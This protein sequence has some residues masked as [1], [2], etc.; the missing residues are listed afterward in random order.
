M[1]LTIAEAPTLEQA[2]FLFGVHSI[3]KGRGVERP[4]L[5]DII[6]AVQE[7]E[8]RRRKIG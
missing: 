8:D 7:L 3:L 2:D 6:E 5:K 4:T 1:T